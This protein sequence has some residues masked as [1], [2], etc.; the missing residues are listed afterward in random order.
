MK[1]IRYF[2]S[3]PPISG[4]ELVVRGLGIQE[5]MRPGVI[6]RPRGT[7]DYLFMV[8]YD[9][10]QIEVDDGM[11]Q[12]PGGTMIV[13]RPGHGHVYGNPGK[14]WLHSWIHCDGALVTKHL[15]SS[16]LTLNKPFPVSDPWLVDRY[17][18]DFHR[19]LNDHRRP[20]PIIAANLMHNFIRAL[21]R[22]VADRSRNREIPKQMLAIKLFIDENYDKPLSLRQLAAQAHLSIPHLCAQFKKHF[23]IAAKAYGIQLRLD[24]ALYLLQDKTLSITEVAHRVGYDDIYHFS[25]LFKSRYGVSP[26]RGRTLAQA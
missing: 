14:S 5:K 2:F 20:D 16:G 10:I 24:H 7:G 26:K 4:K 1:Q 21:S 13:W 12:F 25:K 18:L 15:Q 3:S 8:F 22:A 6:N 23:G 17:L 19:E 11:R 9:D